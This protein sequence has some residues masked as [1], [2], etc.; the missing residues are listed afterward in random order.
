VCASIRPWEPDFLGE[1]KNGGW[2]PVGGVA[3][4]ALAKETSVQPAKVVDR[5][6][7]FDW[8]VMQLIGME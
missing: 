2:R 7:K 3:L 6:K 8:E 5:M 1:G 4:Q